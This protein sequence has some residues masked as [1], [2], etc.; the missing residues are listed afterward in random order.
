MMESDNLLIEEYKNAMS[1]FVS[2]VTVVTSFNDEKP[3]GM[4]VSSFVSVS[5]NPPL[6]LICIDNRYI[7]GKMIKKS[8]SF[9]INILNFEQKNI[10]QAFSDHKKTNA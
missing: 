3:Y 4:T 1:R 2:G 10:G 6:V 8:G 9:A 7:T 5:L